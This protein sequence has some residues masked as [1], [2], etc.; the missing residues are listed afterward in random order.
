MYIEKRVNN[1]NEICQG[2]IESLSQGV[3]S[4]SEVSQN[5]IS[6]NENSF[7]N[8]LFSFKE[9]TG[10]ETM[11]RDSNESGLNSNENEYKMS[12]IFA[13]LSCVTTTVM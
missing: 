1:Y 13:E 3:T 8:P 6:Y 12:N 7:E 5:L 9:I 2:F 4:D 11:F 10:F